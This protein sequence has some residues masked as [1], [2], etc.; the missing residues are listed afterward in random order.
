MKFPVIIQGTVQEG[1]KMGKQLGFPT[2]NVLLRQQIPE[3]IY[4]SRTEID[5]KTYPS[6]TFIGKALVFKDRI[7]KS[8]TYILQFSRDLYNQNIQVVLL[9]K[10]RENQMFTSKRTLIIQMKKDAEVA[11]E[12]FNL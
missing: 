6:L 8:E 2:A 4:L 12:Y 9:K 1:R 10:I 7:Y 3:G 5:A 11:K